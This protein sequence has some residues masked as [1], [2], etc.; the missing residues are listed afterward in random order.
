MTAFLWEALSNSPAILEAGIQAP[1]PF[2][3][4]VSGLILPSAAL[5]DKFCGRDW[6]ELCPH[7]PEIPFGC[8]R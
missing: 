6:P 4:S 2:R 7:D 8:H 5:L 1:S 3:T